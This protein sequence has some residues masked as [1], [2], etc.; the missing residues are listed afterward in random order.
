[1]SPVYL[2]NNKLLV[3]DGKL[4]ANEACCCCVPTCGEDCQQT[5]TV[6]FSVTGFAG[7]FVFLAADEGYSFDG[8]PDGYD[9]AGAAFYCTVVD[10][11]ATWGIIVSFC[12]TIEGVDSTAENYQADIEA[13][14]NGCPKTGNVTLTEILGE[15]DPAGTVTAS[16]S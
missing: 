9:L 11:C 6:N 8:M 3:V 4:A 13:D 15:V 16:I 1:M 2:H 10:G 12:Y 5:V 14:S 7:E